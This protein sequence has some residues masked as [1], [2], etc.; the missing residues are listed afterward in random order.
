[1]TALTTYIINLESRIDRKIHILNEFRNKNEFVVKV[2]PAQTH[3]YGNMGLWLTIRDIINYEV[4]NTSNE[5]ILICE[6]DHKFTK[7]YSK[8]NF[9]RVLNNAKEI[10]AEL[11]LGG[12]SWFH[13][14]VQVNS[15]LFWIDLFNGFQFSII[16]RS[17][18][19]KI[20]SFDYTE[21]THADIALS[22]LSEKIFCIYPYISIQKEFGY[23]DISKR[24]EIKGYLNSIFSSSESVL[25]NI[26]LVKKYYDKNIS[27]ATKSSQVI[28]YNE[29]NLPISVITK[30]KFSTSKEFFNKPQFLQKFYYVEDQMDSKK[31]W[32][33]VISSIGE[34]MKDG[35]DYVIIST[36]NHCFHENYSFKYIVDSIISGNYIGAD[37]LT[38]ISEL[39]DQVIYICENLFWVNSIS[40]INF[41]VIYKKIF[42]KIL[43]YEFR[44]NDIIFDVLSNITSSKF[45]AFPFI[46]KPQNGILDKKRVPRF[47]D[48]PNS[49][50]KKVKEITL[51]YLRK[52]FR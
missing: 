38:G 4:A 45:V 9:E 29:L 31:I 34:S 13:S 8:E 12:L 19:K 39:E 27:L 48:N 15:N 25:R 22:R 7:S 23:S 3:T 26:E 47:Y 42:D 40:S 16:K 44:K 11:I 51:Q 49:R 10:N 21:N 17:F 33:A 37:I 20:L 14:G 30:M 1:M 35:D 28:P 24:N 18:F 6:D 32:S 41:L 50:F 46:S 36:D 5:Y 52:S 43:N 2:V